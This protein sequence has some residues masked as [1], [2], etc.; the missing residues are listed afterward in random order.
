MPDGNRGSS[1]AES[2]PRL[3]HGRLRHRGRE[4][5]L[6]ALA[7]G[8]FPDPVTILLPGGERPAFALAQHALGDGAM[9]A[10]VKDAGDDPT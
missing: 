6:T 8:H 10:I 7:T 3:D 1:R 5:G 2:A 9:A 4:G